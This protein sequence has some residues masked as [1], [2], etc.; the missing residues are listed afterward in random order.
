MNELR[1]GVIGVGRMGQ[2][3]CRIYA[4]LRQ[5]RLAGVC[6]VDATRGRMV[7]SEY[8]VPY[9]DRVDDLLDRVDAVTLATPTPQHYD[10]AMRCLEHGVH[11]LIEK[12]V[13][14]TLEQAEILCR[15]ASSSGLVVQVG[16]IERFNPAYIELK[17]VLEDCQ[18]LVVNVRRLS[19]YAGSNTD[20]DV[21]FDLMVHDLDLIRD[22]LAREPDGLTAFGLTAFS[23]MVDHA[24]ARL[25]FDGGPLTTLV[26][27]RVTE[28]KVR[29]IEVCAADAY[30]ECDLLDKT[31]SVHRC[32]V[33]EYLNNGHSGVKY[34]QESI[35]ERIQ[36][37]AM[38]PLFLE[39]QSFADS[40]LGA[41]PA[42]V[43][44]LDGYRALELAMRIRRLVEADSAHE[45][46]PD[47]VEPVAASG[48]SA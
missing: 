32:T 12:P 24:V 6:D 39:L 38:E 13:T 23:G 22:L 30:V 20:T 1:A 15:A 34:R 36:V 25:R 48:A 27:S 11:L 42:I 33:G 44:V 17:H 21:V 16:H 4:N 40:I 19:A 28:H 5:T 29:S 26:A 10:L 2:R 35:V 3:H 46:A 18:T 14:E 45:R 9:F 43:S 41:K 8:D 37:P 31:I 47:P 7:A